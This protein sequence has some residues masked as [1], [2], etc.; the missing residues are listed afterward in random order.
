MTKPCPIPKAWGWE[1][2]Q[3]VKA[4]GGSAGIDQETLETF[5]RRLG[6]NRYKLWNRLC[7]GSH[8]PPPAKAVPIP[9]K[10]GGV[11]VL[12]VP[13][14]VDRVAQTVAKR[15]LEPLLEPVFH[16]DSVGLG[17]ADPRTTRWRGGA[18]GTTTA[19]SSLTSRDCSTTSATGC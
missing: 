10:S 8:F 14:V 11:R 9:K 12:G 13:T 18:A 6:G 2:Y 1:A 3:S 5:A 7:S 4:N 15:V 16:P 17:Q 19:W